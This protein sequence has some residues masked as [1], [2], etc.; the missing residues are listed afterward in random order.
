MAIEFDNSVVAGTVLVRDAIQSQNFGVDTEGEITGWQIAA[1]GSSSFTSTTISGPNYGIDDQGVGSFSTVNAQDDVL[2]GGTS[3]TGIIAGLPDGLLSYGDSAGANVAGA[4]WS[5]DSTAIVSTV[6]PVGVVEMAFGPIDSTH[7]YRLTL[8]YNYTISNMGGV[9][10]HTL[11]YTTDGSTPT[12]SGIILD[13]SDFNIAAPGTAPVPERAFEQFFYYSQANYDVIRCLLTFVRTSAIG[14]LT[15]DL[16]NA[17]TKLTYAFEDLGIRADA[18]EGG[19]L[20]QQSKSSGTPDPPPTKTYTHTYSATWS[21]SWN[22]GGSSVNV[23]NGELSQ[24]QS[25]ATTSYGNRLSWVGFNFNDIQSDLSGAT[26]KKVEVF[27]YF[28]HWYNNAG[29]TAVIGTHRSTATSAPSYNGSL[30]TENRKTV[31]GWAANSGKWVDITSSVGTD[32]KTGNA[33][34]IVVGQGNTTSQV[35]YGKARGYSQSNAPKLRITY[36]K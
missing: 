31:T 21:R 32:F 20:S 17:N 30:D 6:T 10:R 27:L 7:I 4:Q 3:L 35:Y 2:I 15:V 16:D 12:T 25:P 34:G 36:T 19:S 22:N 33:T 29:G 11:R 26:V 9:F 23:T 13:G 5:V 18:V 1:D 24:G 14:T 8:A 28:T